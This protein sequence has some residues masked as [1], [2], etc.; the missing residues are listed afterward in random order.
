MRSSSRLIG[1]NDTE[2]SN[3]DIFVR[4]TLDRAR[5]DSKVVVDETHV[6]I[7]LKEGIA[8]ETLKPGVYPIVNK[9]T[10]FQ[11]SEKL[12][13]IKIE[14]FY[15]SKTAEIKILWGTPVLFDVHDPITDSSAKMGASGEI[16]IR[17]K[18][19]RQFYLEV[20]G[21]SKSFTVDDLKDRIKGKMLAIIEPTIA[22]FIEENNIP[23][24]R[25]SEEKLVL[26]KYVEKVL[27][28]MLSREYGL[29]IDSFI[30]NSTNIPSSD[31]DKSLIGRSEQKTVCP[32][33]G[34]VLVSGSIFCN[35]CG[36]RVR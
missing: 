5:D 8:L 26:S 14:L 15:I 29:N 6:A 13:S 11:S 24:S 33:C 20:V 19:P 34:L 35:N 21:S 12:S 30:I 9:G 36:T 22:D 7:L 32:N 31:I 4:K 27:A 23:L 28:K 17:V 25:V 18:N 2:L 3:D 1:L 10:L 16:E